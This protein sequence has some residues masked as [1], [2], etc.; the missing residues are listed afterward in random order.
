MNLFTNKLTLSV[1]PKLEIEIHKLPS[2]KASE[3]NNRT[4]SG[5]MQITIKI[6]RLP[7]HDLDWQECDQCQQCTSREHES[8]FLTNS[9]PVITLQ[10]RVY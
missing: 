2:V 8:D 1:K 5:L 3:T 6:L 4:R 7:Q 10:L 9:P